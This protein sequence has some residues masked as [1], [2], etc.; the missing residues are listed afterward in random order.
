MQI[1]VIDLE[2]RRPARSSLAWYAGIGTMAAL[3]LIEWPLAA[4]VA[5]SHLISQDSRAPTVS[6]AAEGAGSGAG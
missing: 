4:V 6:D 5:T 3:G 1:P 2:V